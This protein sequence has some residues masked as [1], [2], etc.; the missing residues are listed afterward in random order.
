MT[1][2]V[3]DRIRDARVAK[4]L[5]QEQVADR[6]GVSQAHISRIETG[7]AIPG[8]G[9]A[10]ALIILLDLSWSDFDPYRCAS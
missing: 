8:I 7:D 5:T 4:G 2:P 6:V 10:A 3:G 1:I 9:E